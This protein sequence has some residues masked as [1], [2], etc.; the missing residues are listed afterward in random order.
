MHPMI[1][2]EHCYRLHYPRRP[3][4]YYHQRQGGTEEGATW[5]LVLGNSYEMI[6]LIELRKWVGLA[7]LR[8]MLHL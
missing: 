6:Y 2:A 5:R 3:A 1:T 7:R 4:Q 8:I